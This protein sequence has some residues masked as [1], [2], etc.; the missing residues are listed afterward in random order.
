LSNIAEKPI[1]VG[2]LDAV[3]S[4]T[5]FLKKLRGA[6]GLGNTLGKLEADYG[7]ATDKQLGTIE[8]TLY[9]P[10]PVLDE[11]LYYGSLNYT[12][13]YDKYT[14]DITLDNPGIYVI[15]FFIDF[16]GATHHASGNFSNVYFSYSYS[17]PT[18]QYQES[19]YSIQQ[20]QTNTVS[21]S[22]SSSGLECLLTKTD[23]ATTFD[24]K[25][26]LNNT[27]KNVFVL[28]TPATFS[29]TGNFSI[30]ATSNIRVYKDSKYN[31]CNM[32]AKFTPI[33]IF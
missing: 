17:C 14:N 23:T 9:V 29:F 3:L 7:G 11:D 21:S 5:E 22:S 1:S 16:L 15:E 19:K 8:K 25:R 6:M 12:W 33:A 32:T 10:G 20:F 4:D 27:Y 13:G 2:N 18:I 24:A 31:G 30:F 28:E 26:L